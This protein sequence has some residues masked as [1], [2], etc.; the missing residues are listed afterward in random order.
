MKGIR[1]I[2]SVS[3]KMNSL[4]TV[5]KVMGSLVTFSRPERVSRQYIHYLRVFLVMKSYCPGFGL[6]TWS[7]PW[8]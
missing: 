1:Y 5:N 4:P 7:R 2:I 8:H 6:G 3:V